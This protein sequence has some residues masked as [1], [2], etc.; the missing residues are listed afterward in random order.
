MAVGPHSRHMC[1]GG[2]DVA[3]PDGVD[4][5]SVD[6]P[7][8]Q[9]HHRVAVA[10]APYHAERPRAA[11]VSRALPAG[12]HAR[13]SHDPVPPQVRFMPKGGTDGGRA[14]TVATTE[15]AEWSIELGGAPVAQRLQVPL[16]LAYAISIHKVR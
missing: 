12:T 15:P 13:L 9:L 14:S 3:S 5:D 2:W 4:L 7:R 16:R 1:L 6:A 11:A 8:A 10:A